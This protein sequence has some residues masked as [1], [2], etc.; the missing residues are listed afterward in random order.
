VSTPLTFSENVRPLMRDIPRSVSSKAAGQA[1]GIGIRRVVRTWLRD[2]DQ[3]KP[4]QHSQD[5]PGS[6]S[7]HYYA[8]AAESV[9]VPTVEG[10]RVYVSI[11]QVGFRQRFLG[12]PIQPINGKYLTI[13]GSALSYGT[14][15]SEFTDL[16]FALVKDDQGF[17]RPALVSD[18]GNQFTGTAGDRGKQGSKKTLTVGDVVFWLVRSVMQQ[19]DPS[20]VP[21]P[22]YIQAG[23]RE[24]LASY[25][26]LPRPTYPMTGGAQ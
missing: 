26:R 23:A 10:N 22:E 4:S 24:G 13:P 18:E 16:K 8:K 17:L 1:V 14:R 19:P 20:I 3:N 21:G 2:L 7:T 11:T 9:T 15:A 5:L 12:G 6:Q 25:L